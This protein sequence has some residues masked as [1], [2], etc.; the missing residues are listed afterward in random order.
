VVKEPVELTKPPVIVP[1][2]PPLPEREKPNL[3]GSTF[4]GHGSSLSAMLAKKAQHEY[5]F[6]GYADTPILIV[7]SPKAKGF[8]YH[9]GFIGS[10]GTVLLEKKWVANLAKVAFTPPADGDY[11]LRIVGGDG[12][13]DYTLAA[14]GVEGD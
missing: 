9:I 8:R 5:D 14:R 10:D 12:F 7:T 1:T 6:T 13:G 3:A 11:R 4:H 2:P